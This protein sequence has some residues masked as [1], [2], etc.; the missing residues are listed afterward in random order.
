MQMNRKTAA[1]ILLGVISII[2]V[3]HLLIVFKI[4]P[5]KIAWGGRLHNDKEMYA[6]E[7]VSIVINLFFG[8][9]ISMKAGFMQVRRQPLSEDF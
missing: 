9:I 6:F 8:W 5:Y 7:A 4:I 2:T 3:F 1:T